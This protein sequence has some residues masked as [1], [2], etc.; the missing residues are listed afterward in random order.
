MSR[1]VT[2][3]VV[4]GVAAHLLDQLLNLPDVRRRLADLPPWMRVE[5]DA[6]ARAIGQAAADHRARRGAATGSPE[7]LDP[8][9]ATGSTVDDL[10]GVDQAAALLGVSARR[11][12]QLA[13]AL[14]VKN[15]GRWW[16]ARP[17]VETLREARGDTRGTV[18]AGRRH[19]RAHG[20]RG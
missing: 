10:I 13:P 7:L 6:A 4:D 9:T 1:Y 3:A 12:R 20:L 18:V 17:L 8:V 14:G 19:D 15:G 2:G 11:V 5:L 16:L